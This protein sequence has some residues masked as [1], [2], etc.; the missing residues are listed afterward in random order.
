LVPFRDFLARLGAAGIADASVEV[1]N[2]YDGSADNNMCGAPPL[3]NGV[4]LVS[5]FVRARKPLG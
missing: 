3:P 5:G 2:V 4:R 1:T